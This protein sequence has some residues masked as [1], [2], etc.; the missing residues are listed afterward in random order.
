VFDETSR[1]DTPS[2]GFSLGA[3]AGHPVV[4]VLTSTG[5]F[6]R[7]WMV[8]SMVAQ[9]TDQ[10]GR[11]AERERDAAELAAA[12]DAAM[13]ASRL[14][15]SFLAMM[16]HEIRT[17]M[18]GV[19]GLNELLLQTELDADQRRLA[20][21]VQLAG[22]SLLGLINDILDFSKIEAGQLELE[23]VPFDIRSVLDQVVEMLGPTAADKGIP[24]SVQVEDDVPRRVVGDPTRLGQVLSNLL[25]NAVKFTPRG[26]VTVAAHVAEH[27]GD[28][29]LLE[30]TVTDTGIGIPEEQQERLFE[31]FR[32][33]DASTTRTH[34]GTGLGLAIARQLVQALGG[35][36]DVD[37]RTGIG[38]RFRF[39]ARFTVPPE[40]EQHAS[41]P[42]VAAVESADAEGR[43]RVLVVEDND[44]NQLVALGILE[45]LGYTGEVA[46][47]GADA[48]E[49]VA[50]RQYDAVLMDIQM[51]VM[52]GVTA[53][54]QIRADEPDGSRVPIIAMTASA[55]TG[56]RERCL[57]AGMDDFLSKPVSSD[58]LAASLQTQLS[59]D[60]ASTRPASQQRARTPDLDPARLDEL[61]SMGE[62]AV[63]LVARAISNFV[64]GFD[65]TWDELSTAARTGDASTLRAV[66]HRLKGSALNLGARRVAELCQELEDVG[67][68]GTTEGVTP[69]LELLRAAGSSAVAA[70]SAYES[71]RIGS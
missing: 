60:T 68:T 54:R 11:V 19:I 9:V 25:S 66:A 41:A 27:T 52:D 57:A 65:A 18:N 61:L 64:G 5:P 26:Q 2:V 28:T 36:I 35:E 71:A 17:P 40:N 10:V 49:R 70:L 30:V 16:S 34:G 51:P 56:E 38:S 46:V 43:G 4:V 67:D 48:V 14:K 63:P 13:E 31:P 47:N 58:Q 32:Q 22:R 53:A 23:S 6:R 45:A 1:P 55:I 69:L 24:V 29:V 7:P 62:R 12:R 50:K 33:A 44:I 20:Q 59:A 15:S 21:G 8:R 39:S 37:S 42:V 3:Q